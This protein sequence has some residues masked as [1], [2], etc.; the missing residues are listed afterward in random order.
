MGF[1]QLCHGIFAAGKMTHLVPRAR[2]CEE[3]A[4]GSFNFKFPTAEI[5]V[6]LLMSLLLSTLMLNVMKHVQK[7]ATNIPRIAGLRYGEGS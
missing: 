1:M 3:F 7:R 6:L 5:R 4:L 2:Q